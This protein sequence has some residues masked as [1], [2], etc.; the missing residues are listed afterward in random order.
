MLKLLQSALEN[1]EMQAVL[2]TPTVTTVGLQLNYPPK[3][4]I[5]DITEIENGYC[6]KLFDM[7][8]GQSQPKPILKARGIY[9]NPGEGA[10]YD[11]TEW[12]YCELLFEKHFSVKDQEDNANLAGGLLE[13]KKKSKLSA[14]KGN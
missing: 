8:A 7:P 3:G 9:L 2:Y 1:S 4:I 12:R 13:N 14:T 11:T 5:L 6:V 10:D